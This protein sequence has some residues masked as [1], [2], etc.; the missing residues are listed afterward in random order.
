MK[1]SFRG[2]QLSQRFGNN[3]DMRMQ[4]KTS[5]VHQIN[6]EFQPVNHSTQMREVSA[7]TINSGGNKCS[8]SP[9]QT[10]LIM[11]AQHVPIAIA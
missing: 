10:R 1:K 9:K 8:V 4:G 7:D 3:L 5:P 11:S 2:I 6:I